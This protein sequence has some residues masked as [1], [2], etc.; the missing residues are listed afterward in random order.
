MGAFD[1]NV[2]R[3]TGPHM[4][5]SD[6]HWPYSPKR[7]GADWKVVV[8]TPVRTPRMPSFNQTL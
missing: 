3:E 5:I 2:P 8:Q 1:E 6:I 7:V 4:A